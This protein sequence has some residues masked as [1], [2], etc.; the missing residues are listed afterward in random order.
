VAVVQSDKK[1]AGS[2]YEHSTINVVDG[3]PDLYDDDHGDGDEQD[4]HASRQHRIWKD[5]VVQQSR[6]LAP[7][8]TEVGFHHALLVTIVFPQCS[9]L[10]CRDGVTKFLYGCDDLREWT[11]SYEYPLRV[12]G[13][14]TQFKCYSANERDQLL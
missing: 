14:P 1:E 9:V 13:D 11:L 3:E 4:V 7:D 2:N 5:G 10:L 12:V 6:A 8:Y